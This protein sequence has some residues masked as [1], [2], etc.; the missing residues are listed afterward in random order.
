M[1]EGLSFQSGEHGGRPPHHGVPCDPSST[2]RH[3]ANYN[4]YVEDPGVRSLCTSF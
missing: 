3:M 4:I 2:P 1:E